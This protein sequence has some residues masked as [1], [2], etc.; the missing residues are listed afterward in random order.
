VITVVLMVPT[1]ISSFYGMN[2]PNGMPSK[3]W[4]FYA[5]FLG[6][7]IFTGFL[8]WYMQRRRYF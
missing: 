2:I 7:G 1:L 4:V 8:Y 5:M 3:P 6:T